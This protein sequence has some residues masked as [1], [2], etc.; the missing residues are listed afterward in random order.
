MRILIRKKSYSVCRNDYKSFKNLST[1]I[2]AES[3]NY[4]FLLGKVLAESIKWKPKSKPRVYLQNY[5]V[6]EIFG[7]NRL[8][9]LTTLYHILQ[10]DSVNN[11]KVLVK[12][13]EPFWHTLAYWFVEL[14]YYISFK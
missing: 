4:V 7:S 1:S 9:L 10:N 3:C 12:L 14:K 2:H 6:H 11:Y 8:T 5:V 13:P